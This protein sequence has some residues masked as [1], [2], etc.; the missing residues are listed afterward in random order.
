MLKFLQTLIG[1][2]PD[3]APA[4]GLPRSPD[5][6]E[7]RAGFLRR[8]PTC[9]ACGTNRELQVHHVE[10]HHLHPE[11]EMIEENCMTLCMY[12]ARE[13][14]WQ[15]GHLGLSWSVNNP[16]AREDAARL[17]LRRREALQ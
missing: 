7:W 3:D 17:L 15:V 14:H 11:L 9:E 4:Y 13:C 6:P 16:A 12:R 2:V 10:A 5:W 8:H 1:R